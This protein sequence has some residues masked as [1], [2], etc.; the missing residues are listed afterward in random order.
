MVGQAAV[1]FSVAVMAPFVVMC[2]MGGPK[3][4]TGLR[5]ALAIPREEPVD[6]GKF[7]AVILWNT[8]GQ[9]LA[10]FR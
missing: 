6:W 4:G 2:A 1:L 9:G 5:S 3:V 10:A 7:L 8:S